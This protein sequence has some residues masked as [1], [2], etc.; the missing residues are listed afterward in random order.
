MSDQKKTKAKLISELAELR[1]QIAELEAFKAEHKQAEGELQESEKRY[2]LLFDLLPYGGEV[3]DPKGKIINCSPSTARMLGYEVSE[4]IDKHITELLDPDSVKVFRKKFPQLLS[5]K[6]ASAEI[7]LIR[8]D[9]TKLNI[10]RAAQPILDDTDRV[11]AV[12]ALNVDITERVQAEEA[13]RESEEKYRNL[14]ERANDGV[15]IVQEGIL[16]FVNSR[17][18]EMIGYSAD[19]MI[20]SNFL[21]FVSLDDRPKIMDIYTRRTQGEDVPSVYEMAVSHRDGSELLVEINSG[22]IS[23]QGKPATLS[24]VRDITDRKRVEEALRESEE[25]YRSIYNRVEDVIYET[26]YYG[27]LIGISPSIEKQGGYQPEELIGHNVMDFY[28]YPDEYA[29][30]ESAME[31]EG[32]VNDFE[33]HLKKKNG[34][35]IIVSVTAHIVFDADG[36]PVKTEGILRDITERVQ[37]EEL[38]KESESRATALLEAIPDLMFRLDSQGV[39]LDYKAEKSELYVQEDTIIGKNNR[40]IFSPAFAEFIDQKIGDTLDSGEMQTF[41][42]QLPIPK[43]GLVDYEARMVKSGEDEVIAIVR[44]ETER[45]QA[46]EEIRK[47]NEELEQR[48]IDR[49]TKL[50]ATN[51]ELE[52][53]SYSIS[54]DLRAPLRAINGFSAILKDNYGELLDEEGNRYLDILRTTTLKMDRLINDLLSLSR[55]GRREISFQPVNITAMVERIYA[56]QTKDEVDRGFDFQVADCPI[57]EADTHLL[58]ILLTNLLSNAVKFTRGRDPAVIEFGQLEEEDAPVYFVRDNG[59]GFNMAYVEKLFG[60]FQRLHTEKEFEGTGIGLAIVRRITQRHGGRVWVEAEPDKGAT[61]Y[62][63]LQT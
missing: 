33:I 61:F 16:I 26:D 13:L 6:P 54:H 18:S 34:E 43:R 11:E 22:I 52:A 5:G 47:L 55:L 1:K 57:V 62:F 59:V 53:F 28:A 35:L 56:E 41:E 48:V 8:K 20:N 36:Q 45:K 40:D 58:E 30:Q 4:L 10:L 38:L 24:L 42:Y 25:R 15:I 60:P 39:F 12:L 2:R 29:A 27:R 9:G 31:V 19:K 23:F 51:E 7:R 44:D 21:D 46:E 37:A 17:M 49:T 14:V 3:I 32:T 63:T 50:K